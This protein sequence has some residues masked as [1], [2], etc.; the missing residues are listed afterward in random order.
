VD[1]DGGQDDEA[2]KRGDGRFDEPP[3]SGGGGDRLFDPEVL[4]PAWWVVR[5]DVDY[6]P[7]NTEAERAARAVCAVYRLLRHRSR[8][9]RVDMVTDVDGNPFLIIG[10]NTAGV[11]EMVS[12]L[13]AGARAAGL[14]DD[15]A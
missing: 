2:C 15:S 8:L 3:A 14:L 5:P 10:L 7:G 1:R 9:D 13:R 6:V 4:D 12:L 11:F